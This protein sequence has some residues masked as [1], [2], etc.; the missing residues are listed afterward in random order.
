MH[1][2]QLMRSVCVFST[3]SGSASGEAP[4][5]HFR[6]VH[7]LHSFIGEGREGCGVCV[8]VHVCGLE[9]EKV[10]SWTH[11]PIYLLIMVTVMMTGGPGEEKILYRVSR[12]FRRGLLTSR[13]SV[14]FCT[15]NGTTT[16]VTGHVRHRPLLRSLFPQTSN[17]RGVFATSCFGLHKSFSFLYSHTFTTVIESGNHW[18]D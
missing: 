14:C 5:S 4:P 11:R 13:S 7:S 8:C 1:L 17:S 9:R 16:H 18:K 12:S 6:I 10:T 3:V 15:T 2:Y